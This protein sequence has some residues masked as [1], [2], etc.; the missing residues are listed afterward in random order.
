MRARLSGETCGPAQGREGQGL[1][2]HVRPARVG[3]RKAMGMTLP[4]PLGFQ[5]FCAYQSEK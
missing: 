2:K 3:R 4:P 1:F 5:Q